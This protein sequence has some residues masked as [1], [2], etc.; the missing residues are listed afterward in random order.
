MTAC[1]DCLRRTDLIASIAPGGCRSSSSSGRA[2]GGCSRCATSELLG[3]RRGRRE[4]ARRYAASTPRAA[5]RGR[6]RVGLVTVCRCS[7]AYPERLRDLA[8]PPAVLHVLGDPGALADRTGSRSSA[9]GA[10]P[11]TG[12]RSPARSAAGCRRRG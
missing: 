6:R 9:P 5:R 8:D 3:G 7:D 10:R 1:D 11:R 2:A 12:S 4:V